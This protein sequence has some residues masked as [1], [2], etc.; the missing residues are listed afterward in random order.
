MIVWGGINDCNHSLPI[1]DISSAD[2][3]T[4][5]GALN[6]I[7]AGL[8]RKFPFANILFIT[9]MKA[10]GFKGYSSWNTKS[11]SG[12]SLI[13]YRQA[14]LNI[15]Q[16]HSILVLDLFSESGIT[17]DIPEIKELLLPDGLH[18]SKE[19]YLRIARKIAN[20]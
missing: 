12:V 16:N 9:P 7:T 8:Q 20:V 10:D 17:P 1:G 13:D 3:E 6:L 4:F 18:P 5:Y 15:C 2:P 14:I 11:E 19:G